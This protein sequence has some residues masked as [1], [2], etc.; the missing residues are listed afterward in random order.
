VI[1]RGFAVATALTALG[2]ALL[3]PPGAQATFGFQPGGAGFSIAA[4]NQD[5]TPTTQAGAHPH[6]FEAD[7]GLNAAGGASDGDLRDLTL[8]PPPGFFYNPTAVS[9]CTTGAFRTARNS[10]FEASASGEDCPNSS[11]VGVVGIQLG[12]GTVRHF[13]L[14]NLVPPLGAPAAAGASPFGRPLVF[15]ARLREADAGLDLVLDDLSQSLDLVGIEVTIWGTPWQAVHDGERGDCLNEQT[16]GSFGA[17]LVYDS[18]AAPENLIKSDLTLPTIPCGSP[19][20]FSAFATSWSGETGQREAS[21]PA[22]VKCNKS[23]STLKVQLMTDAAAAR[24]GLAFNLAVNDGGG[25]LN[26]GGIARP[27]IKQTILSLP[28]GLTINPSLGAGLGA[29]SEAEFARESAGS[30]PGAGCP[31]NS[32]IGDV[33]VEGALGLAEPLTGSLYVAKPFDNPFDAMLALYMVARSARR[34]LIV[35]SVGKIEPEA[36]TGRLTATFDQLPRLLYTHFAL[37]LREG[38]RSTLVSPPTCGTYK[39]DLALSSWAEPTVFRHEASSFAI[40]RGEAGGLC[41]PGGAPAF[42]PGLLAGSINPQAAAYTPLYLRMTRTDSEQEITGYSASFPPGLLAKVAGVAR[43]PEAAIEAAKHRS[44]AEELAA[45]S[46]PA[47]SRIGRTEAG[48]GVGGVL[49]WAPGALYLAGPWHGAP[50]S[51]VAVDSALIGPFDLGVVVVR[52][53][54]R[55][56]TRTAQVIADGAASDPI[57]H[58]LAGIPLHVR[59]IRVYIDRPGFTVNPTSCDPMQIR[60]TLSGAGADLFSRADDPLAGSSQRFQVLNCSVLGFKPRLSLRLS[61]GTKRGDYP[62]LRATYLPR[63]GQ[64]NLR[65]AVVTLPPSVFLAQEHL[66]D[67]CT[68]ARFAAEACPRKSIYGHAR[69]ITPLLDEPLQGPVY[70][71]SSSNAVPDLVADLRGAGLAVELVGRIDSRRGG[72]RASFESLPDAPVTKFTMTLPGGKRALLVNSEALC[73]AARARANAR[74]VAQSNATAVLRPRLGVRCAKKKGRGTPRRSPRRRRGGSRG[75]SATSSEIAQRG[76]LRVK[77]D[78]RIA[79]R[80]LP[81]TD[82]APIAVSVAG[83]IATSD[84]SHP[85]QLRRVQIALNRAGRLDRRGL[86]LCRL[87]D[88]QPSTTQNAL[89]ACGQAR[90]GEGTFSAD[91]VI[92]EQSPFPSDGEVVAFNGEQDG[93]PVIFAHVYGTEPIP[94][95][96]TL[97]LRISHAKGRFGTVLSAALPHVTSEAAVVTG[98]TLSLHRTFRYRGEPHSYLSAGCPAPKGFPGALFPLARAS[99]AFAG[100][101]SLSSTVVRSCR[102]R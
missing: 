10:P 37:T 28:E 11:Q 22:M 98:I 6:A 76:D 100:G 74:L 18:A 85:P 8:T 20:S 91:V 87:E 52:S 7:I 96:F 31:N 46:C 89:R 12:N 14:F 29:C 25:I 57:P 48:Y 68:K 30:E 45:P 19:L 5:E 97:P 47:A 66:R 71:R 62:A 36:H 1:R 34:G 84:G 88:I 94:T 13:G 67:I 60:S 40:S 79:P 44:G 72:I 38:Q 63:P 95:S 33:T 102:V 50:L 64:A 81:R 80:A 101:E 39:S 21:A 61:G 59:D 43:C 82:S 65:S 24:T 51:V 77:F 15:T 42:H 3:L 86:P 27:A 9:E 90:V 23:L 69:A 58:I 55:V 70:V 92:P 78:A 53:A 99:F 26:P 35:K 41:P 4:T 54:I 17:C 75:R 93:R 49:A 16:G 83:A 2:I 73:A 32:K 56:D